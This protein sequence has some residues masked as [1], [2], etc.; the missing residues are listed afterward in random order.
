MN[1]LILIAISGR[2]ILLKSIE[3]YIIK[4]KEHVG[5]YHKT[6]PETI[7]HNNL[8]L[9]VIRQEVKHITMR[10]Y[11]VLV[12]YSKFNLYFYWQFEMHT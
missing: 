1:V 6:S 2:F 10:V 9:F 11:T 4:L 8:F 7:W 3:K 12:A 5:W